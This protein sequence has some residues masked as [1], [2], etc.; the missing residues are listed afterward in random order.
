MGGDGYLLE[1]DGVVA[2]HSDLGPLRCGDTQSSRIS[3][4]LKS[5]CYPRYLSVCIIHSILH[6]KSCYLYCVS[7]VKLQS[8]TE[9]GPPIVQD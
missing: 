5:P 2:R 7:M 3:Q 4:G 8:L 1:R 9:S 6:F